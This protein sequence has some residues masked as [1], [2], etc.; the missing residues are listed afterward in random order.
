MEI[1][2]KVYCINCL[3]YGQY[4]K[5]T[6]KIITVEEEVNKYNNEVVVPEEYV[7][8]DTSMNKDGECQ[9]YEEARN[10]LPAIIS[11]TEPVKYKWWQFWK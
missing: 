10:V 3:Y 1:D 4:T 2:K 11:Y 8:A 5:C 7:F 9:Y 6:K